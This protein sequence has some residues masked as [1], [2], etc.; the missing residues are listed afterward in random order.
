MTFETELR[1]HLHAGV[2][3]LPVDLGPLLAGGVAH[4]NKLVRRRR[5]TRILAGAATIA[6]LGGAFAYAG[7]VG[8]A[9]GRG[10]APAAENSVQNKVV[11]KTTA[12][13]PQAALKI[14]LETLPREPA[15]NYRGG[16]DGT[17]TGP[18]ASNKP[19]GVNALVDY[20]SGGS[21]GIVRVEVVTTGYPLLCSGTE[22]SL[23]TLPDGSKLRLIDLTDRMDNKP[24]GYRHLEVNLARPDG[25]NLNLLAVNYQHDN[26]NTSPTRPPVSLA[27]LKAIATNPHWQLKLDQAFVDGAEG[28]F[29]PRLITQP[30][31]PPE[32]IRVTPTPAR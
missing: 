21:T 20:T 11:R 5:L 1:D 10:V 4:G 22:C 14:M 9:P 15:T 16:Y 6:V 24:G 8:D 2:D 19:T 12:I 28:L 32:Q 29:V 23:T 26:P 30:S 27:Q 17:T 13:T 7:S 3:E 18:D 31:G 25:L